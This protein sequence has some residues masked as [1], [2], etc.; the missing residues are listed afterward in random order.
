MARWLDNYAD[1]CRRLAETVL[2]DAGINPDTL[3]D[4]VTVESET[5]RS[6]GFKFHLMT[7]EELGPE[8]DQALTLYERWREVQYLLG[9]SSARNALW[10]GIGLAQARE[11][12][13]SNLAF[14]KNV[15]LGGAIR[16]G[17]RK[18]SDTK[19]G[20]PGSRKAAYRAA[21]SERRETHPDE[22]KTAS[23]R[24]V[25]NSF[26]LSPVNGYK[27]IERATKGL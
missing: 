20:E 23:R 1:D 14:R 18:G 10:H 24:F 3:F 7:R 13:V 15:E 11:H 8:V 22:P 26:G 27:T 19:H 16:R 6:E 9:D 17:G 12:L 25:A 2:R 21:Y 5:G 4:V